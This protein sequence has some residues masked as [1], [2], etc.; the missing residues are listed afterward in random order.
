MQSKLNCEVLSREVGLQVRWSVVA[1]T[2]IIQVVANLGKM[3]RSVTRVTC[4]H[5]QLLK[6][7]I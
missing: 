2:A 7:I 4:W 5:K 6:M 1:D 3:T